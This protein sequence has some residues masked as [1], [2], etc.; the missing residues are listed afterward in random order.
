MEVAQ[1]VS[2]ED[3]QT[4]SDQPG[5]PS[6]LVPVNKEEEHGNADERERFLPFL[7]QIEEVF[8]YFHSNP[9]SPEQPEAP[10]TPPSFLGPGTSAE[11][12]DVHL[13]NGMAYVSPPMPRAGRGLAR[14][15]IVCP[16]CQK[17]VLAPSELTKHMRSHTGERPFPCS[18]CGM[19]FSLKSS[20]KTHERLHSGLRPY[21]CSHCGKDYTLSHHLKRHMRSHFRDRSSTTQLQMPEQLVLQQEQGPQS[22]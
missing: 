12:F 1:G 20:L 17:Q 7:P 9:I 6:K 16:V 5:G 19:H 8:G 11:A 22:A 13:G 18:I 15:P 10:P 3:K 2:L 14:R 21:R 4:Q